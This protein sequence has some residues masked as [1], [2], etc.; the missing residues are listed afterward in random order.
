VYPENTNSRGGLLLQGIADAISPAILERA[1]E[2]CVLLLS[3]AVAAA[4][5]AAAAAADD[6]AASASA[7]AVDYFDADRNNMIWS[8]SGC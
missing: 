4:A 5:A 2:D 7:V 6:A 8:C 3:D 1:R